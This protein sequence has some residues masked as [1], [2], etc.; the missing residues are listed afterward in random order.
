MAFLSRQWNL[1][2]GC[3]GAVYAV[4]RV[5]IQIVSYCWILTNLLVHVYMC[6]FEQS[7]RYQTHGTFHMNAE[8]ELMII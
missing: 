6:S 1:F 5:G 7:D 4:V 2:C 3:L 8:T